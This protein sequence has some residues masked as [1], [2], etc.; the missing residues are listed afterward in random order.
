MCFH[1]DFF[2]FLMLGVCL[3]SWICRFIVSIKFWKLMISMSLVFFHFFPPALPSPL[4]WDSSYV[5]VRLPT[6]ILQFSDTVNF[7]VVFLSVSFCMASVAG[8]ISLA[9]LL[10]CLILS[11]YVFMSHYVSSSQSLV[12]FLLK[13]SRSQPCDHGEYSLT[14]FVSFL[15]Y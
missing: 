9:F 4:L 7:L 11:M 10:P 3:G 8:S 1:T 15:F 5:G 6:G 13:P 12:W 2:M 14:V